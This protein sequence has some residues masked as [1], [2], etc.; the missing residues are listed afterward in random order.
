MEITSINSIG[1]VD[2]YTLHK[3]MASKQISNDEKAKF[4]RKNK[5]QINKIIE[6]KISSKDFDFIMKNRPLIKFRPL[7]NSYTKQGDKVLLATALGVSTSKVNGLIDIAAQEIE[8]NHEIIFPKEQMDTMKSYVYRHGTKRQ[9]IAFLDYELSNAKDLLKSLYS[10]LSYETGGVADYFSRPIHRMDNNTLVDMYVVIDKHLHN[11]LN[12]GTITDK[13]HEDN[14][15][16]IL[17]RIY[18]IQNNSTL[19]GAIKAYKQLT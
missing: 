4:I 6:E 10:T 18:Q 9:V 8:L 11:G 15:K 2:F 7:K 3:V 16:W 13:E 5:S 12:N 19:R 14:A 17:T 1:N